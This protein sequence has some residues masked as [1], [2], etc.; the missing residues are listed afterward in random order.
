MFGVGS[1]A[2]ERPRNIMLSMRPP[3]ITDE[4]Y[5]RIPAL[6]EQ[7]MTKAE[8]AA[9]FGVTLG[10]LGVCCSRRGISL[11]KGGPRSAGATTQQRRA[12][13]AT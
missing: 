4:M 8:I 9:M 5:A 11:R 7:G 12:E 1:Q 2:L 3:R 13:V 6:L 10:S